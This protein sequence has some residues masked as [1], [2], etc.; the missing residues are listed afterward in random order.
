VVNLSL[1][2]AVNIKMA[3]ANKKLYRIFVFCLSNLMIAGETTC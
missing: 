3:I 2:Q 1:L